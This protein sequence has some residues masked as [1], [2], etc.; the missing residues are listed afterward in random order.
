LVY[1]IR[2]CNTHLYIPVYRTCHADIPATT[3]RCVL[4]IRLRTYHSSYALYLP[5]LRCHLY[6]TLHSAS[7]VRC[8]TAVWTFWPLPRHRYYHITAFLYL[9]LP[10]TSPHL[11]TAHAYHT[12]THITFFIPTHLVLAYV[13]SPHGFTLLRFAFL[14]PRSYMYTHYRLCRLPRL[15]AATWVPALVVCPRGLPCRSPC[16]NCLHPTRVR[17][18]TP[19]RCSPDTRACR[20]LSCRTAFR[21]A[22]L[23]LCRDLIAGTFT[24]PHAPPLTI[25]FLDS[26]P[27]GLYAPTVAY[28][29]CR[30]AGRG[31]DALRVR[32]ACVP[33]LWTRTCIPR[34]YFCRNHTLPM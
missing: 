1:A 4:H 13:P 3:A 5:V 31:L 11:H 19:I 6:K 28:R 22:I 12:W 15:V 25:P 20:C 10:W 17:T 2:I 23:P 9:V 30:S 24:T 29:A 34:C 33:C 16:T 7:R 18:Y 32:N 21:G 14:A 26:V 8:C 27:R